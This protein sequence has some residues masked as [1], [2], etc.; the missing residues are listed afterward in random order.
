MAERINEV[1]DDADWPEIEEDLVPESDFMED[2]GPF[3]EPF[4]YLNAARMTLGEDLHRPTKLLAITAARTLLRVADETDTEIDPDDRATFEA[5]AEGEV[6]A[7]KQAL[8]QT[9]GTLAAFTERNLTIG[10]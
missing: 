6:P 1:P 4:E 2:A 7:E 8:V 5:I 9:L 10:E 3:A